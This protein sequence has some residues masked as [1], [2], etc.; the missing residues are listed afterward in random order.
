MVIAV[1]VST[2]LVSGVYAA[3]GSATRASDRLAKDAGIEAARA[4]AVELLRCDLRS[5]TTLKAT[6]GGD[7]AVVLVLSG[8]SDLVGLG[9]TRRSL[10]EVRYLASGDGLIRE[11]GSGKPPVR[12]VQGPVG[13]EF[14]ENAAWKRNAPQEPGALRITFEDPRESLAALEAI[15]RCL[16]RRLSIGLDM[17]TTGWVCSCLAV[18]VV[19]RE[20][21]TYSSCQSIFQ[22]SVGASF[23]RSTTPSPQDCR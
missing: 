12:L 1:A 23:R 20:R 5:R 16:F 13:I 11:E 17:D 18:P 7:G 10:G 9:E 19:A 15:V 2:V 21:R 14:L 4:R 8:L 6:V 3:L 22:P